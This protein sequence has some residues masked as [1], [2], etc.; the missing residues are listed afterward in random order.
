MLYGD[1]Y[2]IEVPPG[3]EPDLASADELGSLFRDA[4]AITR[5]GSAPDRSFIQDRTQPFLSR[6]L[7]YRVDADSLIEINDS[8]LH[9]PMICPAFEKTAEIPASIA[10]GVFGSMT[11]KNLLTISACLTV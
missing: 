8:M 7:C 11:L 2:C 5:F 3:F 6:S 4:R 10:T 1:E 9:A